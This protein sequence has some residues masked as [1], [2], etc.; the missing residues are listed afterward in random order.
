MSFTLVMEWEFS[1]KNFLDSLPELKIKS[2]N[3]NWE[4]LVNI[5]DGVAKA[6]IPESQLLGNPHDLQNF[7]TREL[8]S[9]FKSQQFICRETFTL[10]KSGIYELHIDGHRRYLLSAHFDMGNANAICRQFLIEDENGNTI[11]DSL[12]EQKEYEDFIR[13][14][15][16]RFIRDDFCLRWVLE[17]YQKSLQDT[18]N[19]FI[20]LYDVKEAISNRLKEKGENK[21]GDANML[22][23]LSEFQLFELGGK[24][25]LD[26][27]GVC[28]NKSAK[29]NGEFVC[30]D[31]RCRSKLKT[32]SKKHPLN[33]FK[34]IAN[35]EP[36]RQGRHRGSSF[37]DL[38]DATYE[39]I[40]M[41]DQLIRCLIEAY[42][43]FL[44]KRGKVH[45]GHDNCD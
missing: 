45:F 11:Y 35:N 37:R 38:R 5:Q 25:I 19:R 13:Q 3:A 42:L 34:R 15:T 24:C 22:E 10:E 31:N 36:I 17:S 4:Y 8:E 12:L 6:G 26:K 39:E 14:T 2:E 7:L 43:R 27:N 20:Y 28:R 41:A 33:E 1:P 29:I 21:Q 16:Q 30:D 23:I 9:I 32:F 40:E 44:D 18:E